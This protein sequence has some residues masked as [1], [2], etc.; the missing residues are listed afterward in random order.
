MDNSNVPHNYAP[1]VSIDFSHYKRV[2]AVSDIH[3]DVDGFKAVLGKI[4]F[5]SSDAL[6]IV[7]DI[8]EKGPKSL[9]VLHEVINLMKYGNVYMVTGNNDVIFEEWYTGQVTAEQV[10]WYMH[11]RENS[12]LI[13]MA[14]EL[15]MPYETTEEIAE[16]KD[17]IQKH[18]I[19]ELSFL[20]S[21]P[22]II[23]SE[24]ATFVHAGL[25]PG[26]LHE[27]DKD[28]CLTAKEFGTQRFLQNPEDKD[29]EPKYYRFE[30]P[31]VVGHWPTSNYRET[32]ININ[33][34]YNDVTNIYSIDGGNSMKK[35]RQITYLIFEKDG[36]ITS[37]YYDAL[38]KIKILENQAATENPMSATFP[39]TMVEIKEKGEKESLCYL[40]CINQELMVAN[41]SIYTYKGKKY[42]SD[43][44]TYYLEVC[45]DEIV[46]LCRVWG[47]E[48]LI[49]KE[50]IVGKYAGKYIKIG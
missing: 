11:T 22:Y 43:F 42:R 47:D 20:Y 39:N 19:E 5:S 36:T 13:E 29:A 18:Y 9:A 30:K 34:Y 4:D 21:L 33:P 35:W 38:P 15:G 2:I 23:D 12:I 24:I 32:I 27:Q 37:G 14:K 49:K 28:Y 41:S 26:D 17:A 45:A 31:V 16:L 46:S 1:I 8:L 48:V 25:K 7:G 3:G 50:G 44:T 6:V 40:P 10:H